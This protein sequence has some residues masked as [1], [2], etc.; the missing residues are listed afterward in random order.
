MDLHTTHRNENMRHQEIKIKITTE[1]VHD[2]RKSGSPRIL[3]KK[4]NLFNKHAAATN[5][6]GLNLCM[7]R[8]NLNAQENLT[9]ELNLSSEGIVQ[10][11]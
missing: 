5:L 2:Y 6:K 11:I 7:T 3:M 10:N 8:E 9:E 4:F 1:S